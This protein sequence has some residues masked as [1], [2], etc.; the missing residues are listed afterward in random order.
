MRASKYRGVGA[1]RPLP[2]TQCQQLRALWIFCPLV[3]RSSLYENAS[4]WETASPRGRRN[5]S[6]ESSPSS[7]TFFFLFKKFFGVLILEM[8]PGLILEK[9]LFCKLAG[10]GLGQG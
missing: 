9:L 1:A 2:S 7:D 5:A 3:A 8:L 6:W 4:A 10:G